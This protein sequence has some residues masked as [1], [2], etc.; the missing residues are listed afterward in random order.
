[1]LPA[2]SASRPQAGRAYDGAD[3]V[4]LAERLRVRADEGAL[5][6]GRP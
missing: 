2:L 1:M 4:Q 3:R 6:Y 5:A